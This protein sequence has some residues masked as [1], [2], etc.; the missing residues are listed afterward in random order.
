MSG[1]GGVTWEAAFHSWA[2]ECG[3]SGSSSTGLCI[4]QHNCMNAI[5]SDLCHRQPGPRLARPVS[6]VWRGLPIV[7]QQF[8]YNTIIRQSGLTR[9]QR[10]LKDPFSVHCIISPLY[11][12]IIRLNLVKNI[13]FGL[14]QKKFFL[15]HWKTVFWVTEH[16]CIKWTFWKNAFFCPKNAFF[17]KKWQFDHVLFQWKIRWKMYFEKIKFSPNSTYSWSFQEVFSKELFSLEILSS[18]VLE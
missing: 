2:G 16:F 17:W 1:G 5:E 8:R 9:W 7:N 11:Y 6:D 18:C 15:T 13:N 14:D 10:T 3:H 4:L 12:V